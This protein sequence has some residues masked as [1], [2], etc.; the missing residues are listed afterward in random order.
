MCLLVDSALPHSLVHPCATRVAL[1]GSGSLP[2]TIATAR[3]GNV[4]DERLTPLHLIPGTR[5]Y[6]DREH[7]HL[8]EIAA[9][10]FESGI[11]NGQ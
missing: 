2:L 9:L 8:L 10:S 7:A 5:H 11:R 1:S 4:D 6:S 3:S